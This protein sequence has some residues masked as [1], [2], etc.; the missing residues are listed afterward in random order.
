MKPRFRTLIKTIRARFWRIKG[1]G[2]AT[3]QTKYAGSEN[4][5][6][7]SN[8]FLGRYGGGI[9]GIV[10]GQM[11]AGSHRA[12]SRSGDARSDLRFAIGVLPGNRMWSRHD[13]GPSPVNYRVG[14]R[15]GF[16]EM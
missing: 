8:T 1:S 11:L 14:A 4:R 5:R 3:A 2:C 9:S 10:N 12:L 13:V 15:N 16:K 6:D 7:F